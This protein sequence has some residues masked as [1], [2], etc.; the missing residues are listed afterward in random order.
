M[1]PSTLETLG[2]GSVLEIFQRGRLPAA[3]NELVDRVFG[4]AGQRGA[5]VVSGANGIVGAGKL[6]QLGARL[7]PYGVPMVA[8]DF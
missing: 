6:M 3:T 2:L 4:S 7:E 5:L 1:R 8:L